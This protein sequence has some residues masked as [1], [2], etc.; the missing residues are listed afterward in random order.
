MPAKITRLIPLPIP[1][2]VI[3]SPSHI[4]SIEPALMAVTATAIVFVV[5]RYALG[6]T[7]VTDPLYLTLL[8][9]Q[10]LDAS[11]TSYGID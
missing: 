11:A 6:W 5:M 9:G 4:S 1:C 7:Y 2:S 3:N 8:F 10:L